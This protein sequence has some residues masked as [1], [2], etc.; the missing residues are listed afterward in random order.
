[1]I[2][3]TSVG[4]VAPVVKMFGEVDGEPSQKE[5]RLKFGAVLGV[6]LLQ[7]SFDETNL[8]F[9]FRAL[10]LYSTKV[11]GKGRADLRTL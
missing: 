6:F 2:P 10:I 5:S 11:E 4:L 9:L 1:M 3:F 8:N 7:M